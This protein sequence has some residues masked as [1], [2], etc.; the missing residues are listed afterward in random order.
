MTFDVFSIYFHISEGIKKR[1]LSTKVEQIKLH[2]TFTYYHSIAYTLSIEL[3]PPTSTCFPT[4]AQLHSCDPVF[5]VPVHPFILKSQL[6]KLLSNEQLITTLL[7]SGW[8]LTPDTA[9]LCPSSTLTTFSL[10]ISITLSMQ[11]SPAVRSL[12]ESSVNDRDLRRWWWGLRAV[13]RSFLPR[14]K[15]KQPPVELPAASSCSSLLL[16]REV[17]WSSPA[18]SFRLCSPVA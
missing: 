8:H 2:H 7:S 17:R 4:T 10:A 15:R 6:L 13:E 3:S 16:V 11:S 18:S 14:L 1:I 12:V 9:S 5:C